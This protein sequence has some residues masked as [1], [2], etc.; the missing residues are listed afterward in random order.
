MFSKKAT[1]F[2]KIFSIDLTLCSKCQIDGE[3]FVNFCGILRKHVLYLTIFLVFV[4]APLHHHYILKIAQFPLLYQSIT[5]AL[6]KPWRL[7]C[8]E[9][10][11]LGTYLS[12]KTLLVFLIQHGLR[13]MQ[14]CTVPHLLWNKLFDK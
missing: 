1:K 2:D 5:N 7:L 4:S 12:S 13:S 14:I 8:K 9:Q 6:R 3:D 10:F 11:L